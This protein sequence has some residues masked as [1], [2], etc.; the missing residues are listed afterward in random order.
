[1][2]VSRDR[3]PFVSIDQAVPLRSSDHVRFSIELNREAYAGLVWIDAHGTIEEIF[4]SDPEVGHRGGEPIRRLE[5]P[6]QLDRG[7]PVVG[8]G[9]IET[10]VLVISDEPLPQD[11]SS[12]MTFATGVP[13]RP[14]PL[15]R[16]EA[17]RLVATASSIDALAATSATRALGHQTS[18]VDDPVLNLLE[19]LRKQYDIIHA[20]SIRHDN[21]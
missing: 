15:A 2:L 14:V 20:L 7:W 17:S 18:Q 6:Q 13:R 1:M 4:P 5:S 10:A 21:H 3:G 11:I 9:G 8:P 12:L 16:Y 19:E